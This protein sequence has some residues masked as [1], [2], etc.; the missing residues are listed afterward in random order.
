M[1]FDRIHVVLPDCDELC[2]RKISGVWSV[3]S[4]DCNDSGLVRSKCGYDLEI[5][6][7]KMETDQIHRLRSKDAEVVV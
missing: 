4:L 1:D 3:R 5:S 6:E 2:F 7:R